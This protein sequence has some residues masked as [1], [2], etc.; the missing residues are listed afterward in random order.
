MEA[1]T[2]VDARPLFIDACAAS[3]PARVTTRRDERVMR[4]QCAD[5]AV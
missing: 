3:G 5:V 4:R 1:Q 2:M